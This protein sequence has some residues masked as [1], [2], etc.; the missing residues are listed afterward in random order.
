MTS[1]RKRE[2]IRLKDEGKIREF[3]RKPPIPPNKVVPLK[4]KEK[5]EQIIRKEAEREL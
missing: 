2:E 3:K 4:N 1:K 5:L